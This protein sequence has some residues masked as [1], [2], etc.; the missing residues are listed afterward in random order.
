[1]TPC[2]LEDTRPGDEFYGPGIASGTSRSFPVPYCSASADAAAYSLNV[3]A[4]PQTGSP[5]YYLTAFPTGGPT[6]TDF[7]PS[8]LNA[9]ADQIVANAAIVQAG[10]NGAVS[11][12]ADGDSTDVI[13]D[14]NGYFTGSPPVSAVGLTFVPITPCRLIDTR[15]SNGDFGGPALQNGVTRNFTVPSGSCGIPANAAAYSFNVTAVPQNQS[16]V[17]YVTVFPTGTLTP[18]T[19]TA[20]TLNAFTGQVV[21]NAA[22]VAAG[23]GGAISVYVS[24]GPSDL[25]LDI[26]GYFVP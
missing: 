22:L 3:T 9:F 19:Q 1:M 10:T 13:L 18:S 26:N 17:Y 12:Y 6:P 8:T 14:M 4:V 23:T 11:V 2:R 24:G 20:S 16:P 7:T 25:I 15:T 21:A 5:L